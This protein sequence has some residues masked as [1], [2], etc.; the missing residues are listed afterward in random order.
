[1]RLT[2]HIASPMAAREHFRELAPY[3]AIDAECFHEICYRLETAQTRLEWYKF[4]QHA[5]NTVL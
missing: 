3:D 4:H 1:M 2:E 5:P